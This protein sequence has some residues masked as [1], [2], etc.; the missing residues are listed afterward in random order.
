MCSLEKKPGKAGYSRKRFEDAERDL[1]YL[2]VDTSAFLFFHSPFP[3][4]FFLKI[5]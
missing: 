1:L 5:T 4:S 2:T 3:P